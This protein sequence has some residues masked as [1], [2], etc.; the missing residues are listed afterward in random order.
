M[1]IAIY[2]DV[3]AFAHVQQVLDNSFWPSPGKMPNIYLA[4]VAWLH[5]A[6]NNLSTAYTRVQMLHI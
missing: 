2:N 6:H 5:T 3:F 1:T 4:Y